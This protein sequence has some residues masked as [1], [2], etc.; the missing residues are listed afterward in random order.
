MHLILAT[1][2][3]AR[4]CYSSGAQYSLSHVV[5]PKSLGHPAGVRVPVFFFW[6]CSPVFFPL[7]IMTE[8][9]TL[10]V[11]ELALRWMTN[12]FATYS[13]HTD[14]L[15]SARSRSSSSAF[16]RDTDSFI[17][18]LCTRAKRH[19]TC[20]RTFAERQ[21]SLR[22]VSRVKE[23]KTWQAEALRQYFTISARS[24]RPGWRN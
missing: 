1:I 7:F 13:M 8:P 9:H 14:T 2:S 20:Q 12:L 6:G 21:N 3:W 24:R 22:R 5:D 15:P 10:I 11:N 16:S 19:H 17:T 4:L 18:R 23:G